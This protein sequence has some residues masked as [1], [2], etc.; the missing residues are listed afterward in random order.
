MIK[1]LNILVANDRDHEQV[2]AEMWYGQMQWATLYQEQ[3]YFSLE[4]YPRVDGEA[5]Q[6]PLTDVVEAFQQ[7]KQTY[8]RNYNMKVIHAT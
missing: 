4:V 3:G 7:A 6:F 8:S 5:W 2:F 1:Q